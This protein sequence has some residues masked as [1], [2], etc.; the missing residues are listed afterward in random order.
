MHSAVLSALLAGAGA[1]ALTAVVGIRG[2][3]TRPASLARRLGWLFWPMLAL[4][5]F[6]TEL[7]Y[8]RLLPSSLLHAP[9]I[10]KVAHL[11]LFGTLVFF[12]DLWLRGRDLRLARL[13]LPLALLLVLAGASIEESL[14][15]LSPARNADLLDLLSDLLGMVLATALSRRILQRERAG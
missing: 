14:Q 13:H 2:L 1:L 7:A 5:G 8:L 11:V 9:G 4:D 6:I 3:L 12:L 15:S 10:D